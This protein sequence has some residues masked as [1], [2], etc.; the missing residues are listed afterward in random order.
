MKN[1][2]LGLM[3][4]LAFSSHARADISISI[5]DCACLIDAITDGDTDELD[6]LRL[7][8]TYFRDCA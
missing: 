2:F 8:N 3:A 1:I 6:R 7:L 5:C 4:L